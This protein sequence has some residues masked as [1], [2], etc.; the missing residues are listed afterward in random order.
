MNPEARGEIIDDSNFNPTGTWAKDI[1]L[2]RNQGLEVDDANKPAPQNIPA[3][4]SSKGS[5]STTLNP[6]PIRAGMKS[7]RVRFLMPTKK[8]Q[9]FKMIGL[10]NL[11]YCSEY[12]MSK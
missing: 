9:P 12:D 3:N 6:G 2:V 10:I 1:A 4:S 11:F 7:I 5:D 8:M